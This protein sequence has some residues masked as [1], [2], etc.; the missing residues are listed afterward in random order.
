IRRF[1]DAR[2]EDLRSAALPID[3][4]GVLRKAGDESAT[5][6]LFFARGNE[7]M[8][9]RTR[10]HRARDRDGR[11]AFRSKRTGEFPNRSRLRR[12][13]RKRRFRRFEKPVHVLRIRFGDTS[14]LD[15]ITRRDRPTNL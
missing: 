15:K 13:I 2:L 12:H 8:H 10:I 11:T 5:Y 9:I 7:E 3:E 14:H 6:E 4:Y 1:F